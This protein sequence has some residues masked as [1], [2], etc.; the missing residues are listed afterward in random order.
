MIIELDYFE[1]KTLVLLIISFYHFYLLLISMFITV[2][3]F[4]LMQ[5]A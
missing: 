2:S 1:E 4:L 3:D 5:I